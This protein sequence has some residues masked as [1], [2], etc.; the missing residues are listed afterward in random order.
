MTKQYE[1]LRDKAFSVFRTLA[2]ECEPY[3]EAEV[4][5][6]SADNSV[7]LKR[8]KITRT[9]DIE[10]IER[11]EAVIPTLDTLTYIHKPF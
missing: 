11:I 3:A 1:E 9:I 10:W 6:A 5:L 2:R 8:K 4:L 7:S